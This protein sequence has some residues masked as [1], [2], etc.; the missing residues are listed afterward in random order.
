MRDDLYTGTVTLLF[1]DIEGATRLLDA[2]GTVAYADASKT[3]SLHVH[4]WRS[5]R[6]CTDR[7]Q[8]EDS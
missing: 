1:T 5:V 8:R 3:S 4:F 2:L 7:S 6:E